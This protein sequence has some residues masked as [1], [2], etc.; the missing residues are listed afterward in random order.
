[1]REGQAV[2][3]GQFS[4]LTMAGADR[5]GGPFGMLLMDPWRAAAAPI[6]I[7]TVSTAPATIRSRARA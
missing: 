5:D 1:V 3:K 4:V 2:T 6:S 7:T